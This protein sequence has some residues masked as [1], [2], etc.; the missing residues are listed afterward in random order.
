MAAF[1]CAASL[2]GILDRD[3]RKILIDRIRAWKIRLTLI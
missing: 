1:F 3:T 2:V